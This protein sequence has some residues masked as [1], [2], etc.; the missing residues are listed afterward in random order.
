MPDEEVI[1]EDPLKDPHPIDKSV[2]KEEKI[3]SLKKIP[4]SPITETRSKENF[5][6]MNF[7]KS[8]SRSKDNL[9]FAPLLDEKSI[10]S[11]NTSNYEGE[12]GEVFRFEYKINQQKEPLSI[13]S[14]HPKRRTSGSESKD[15]KKDVMSLKLKA[16]KTKGSPKM[17]NRVGMNNP[18]KNLEPIPSE[19]SRECH[20][21]EQ[22]KESMSKEHQSLDFQS[23]VQITTGNV[24][25]MLKDNPELLDQIIKEQKTGDS[26]KKESLE[27]SQ[28]NSE[29]ISNLVVKSIMKK[30]NDKVDMP[31]EEPKQ[32]QQNNK[33]MENKVEFEKSKGF[34]EMEKAINF[35]ENNG[36]SENNPEDLE[37]FIETKSF[38]ES[39]EIKNIN[40]AD[41]S[42]K[43]TKSFSKIL[44]LEDEKNLTKE[45][46]FNQQQKGIPV[47]N[48]AYSTKTNKVDI[49]GVH[50]S[51]VV[52]QVLQ[53]VNMGYSNEM[54]YLKDSLNSD[55]VKKTYKE[56]IL[57]E[58]KDKIMFSTLQPRK[59]PD[60]LLIKKK[61]V[62]KRK[63][64]IFTKKK[65]NYKSE[66]DF[67]FKNHMNET[68]QNRFFR[69]ILKSK[70]PLKNK[71]LASSFKLKNEFLENK[72]SQFYQ[73]ISKRSI[74]NT[75]D[76]DFTRRMKSIDRDEKK[77]KKTKTRSKSKSRNKETYL[78]IGEEV[79][80]IYKTLN[81][82]SFKNKNSESKIFF[83]LLT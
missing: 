70:S 13:K 75:V 36:E 60:T 11:M 61:K 62:K 1:K 51:E 76:A 74:A 65:F 17:K 53:M 34:I 33:V 71:K 21:V 25:K 38:L 55:K 68:K 64:G 40:K 20:Q 35:V 32:K 19:S 82:K 3:D 5:S 66:I 67:I 9:S 73:E 39:K 23:I 31:E 15:R 57:N 27:D 2:E 59:L 42:A 16:V 44:K 24:I 50:D 72:K 45:I 18:G 12:E 49:R 30:N 22:I 29:K 52:K 80:F 63:P 58:K 26:Q 83:K 43:L 81:S 14:H 48:K 41:I 4:D 10:N 78:R 46:C 7:I 28:F 37:S 79:P 47:S 54:A 77:V 8:K 56:D 69:N 6:K